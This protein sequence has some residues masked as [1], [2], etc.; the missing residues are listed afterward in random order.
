MTES[1]QSEQETTGGRRWLRG[2]LVAAVL[3]AAVIL[4]IVKPA[5]PHRIQLL[6]DSQDSA[7]YALGQRYADDLRSRGLAVD[8][9]ATSGALDNVSRLDGSVAAVAVAPATVDSRM[10]SEAAERQLVAL[11]S[12]GFE[13]VWMFCRVDSGIQRLPDLRGRR[14][15]TEGLGTTGE[16]VARELFRLNG[17]AD[18]VQLDAVSGLTNQQLTDGFASQSFDAVVVSGDA[19]APLVRAALETEGV[20]VLSFERA[21]AYTALI[22]GVTR[23]VAPEGVLDLSRNVPSR[24]V[25]LLAT[26]TCL[27]AHESLHPAVVPLLLKTAENVRE[28][29]AAFTTDVEFPGTHNLTLPLAPAARRWFSQGETGLFSRL[30]YRVTRLLNHIGFFVLPLLAVIAAGC[31][32]IP[33]AMHGWFKFRLQGWLKEL[34]AVEKEH[35]NDSDLA[36]LCARLDRIDSASV[37]MFVPR[38]S[39]H[40]YIDFRQF[41]HDLRD[42]VESRRSRSS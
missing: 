28:N 4:L 21:E 30:P 40:D 16:H 35:V 37:R 15:V 31:K 8:V 9:V 5:M 6:T 42:R 13:P 34:T 17:M 25:Q 39:A 27:I 41:L 38:S 22:P 24:D 32:L 19:G 14:V 29:R 33:A 23:I 11:G 1:A 7:W 20:E 12:I 26:T 18:D 36:E 3:L 10:Q 2:L